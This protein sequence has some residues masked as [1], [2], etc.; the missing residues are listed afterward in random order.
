MLENGWTGREAC[1]LQSALRLSQQGFAARFGISMRTV[2]GW[3][4]YPG[5]RPRPETQKILDAAYADA[6][7]EE[8]ER[9]AAL[10][11][12]AAGGSEP[13]SAG[14]GPAPQGLHN[15]P[16]RGNVFV[17]RAGDL[18]WLETAIEQQPASVHGLGG[19]GKSTLALHFAHRC[20]EERRYN[21]VW[22][23]SAE[24]PVTVTTGLAE[25]A[26][27][28]NPGAGMAEKTSADAAAWAVGWLQAHDG[29]LLVYDDAS[30]RAVE[31]VL[32]TLS[33]GRHLITSRRATGWRRIARPLPLSLLPPSDAVDL[34]MQ[35]IVNPGDDSDR[36]VGYLPLALEQAAAYIEHT[37]IT[38]AGYLDRLRSYPARMLDAAGDPDDEDGRQRTIAR[39]F[40][41]SIRAIAGELPLAGEILAILA[42]L[43][44]DP[45]PRPVAYMLGPDPLTV[46]DALGKLHAYSMITLTPDT[47][48]I[49]RLVQAVARNPAEP[50]AAE[51]ARDRAVA[52]LLGILPPDPLFSPAG[53][54][55]WRELLPHVMALA[56]HV[57]P[58]QDTPGIAGILVAA[59][60]FAQADGHYE[61]A[62][63]FAERAAA[64]FA[65]LRGTDAPETLNA[66]SYLASAYRATGD[67]ATA[68]PLHES[69]LADAERVLGP[70]HP[71]T[72]VARANLAYLLAWQGEPARA[73]EMHAANAAAFERIHGPEHPHALNARANLAT[74]YRDAGDLAESIPLL[75]QSAADYA[76]VYGT[77]HP[78]TVTARS[79][80]A[81]AYQLAGDLDRAIPPLPA[82]P[83]RPRSALRPGPRLDANRP[84]ASQRSR[85]TGIRTRP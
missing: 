42:W 25:L 46:D 63:T 44:P 30:P 61:Q 78:E 28:L 51:K 76:R 27:R 4:E 15:L 70:D 73:A 8:R 47:I 62:V 84:A 55:Q 32:G 75:E 43:G 40:G 57:R 11:A 1:A 48:G 20:R 5:R 77:D 49:H 58:D 53:W 52:A 7:P 31:S 59:S 65:R 67:F 12:S 83:S 79:N 36:E 74:C 14:D 41:L 81:Y 80:L 66:R 23:L 56:G 29:W 2:A 3:A 45:I 71:D 21:P 64:A 34:L 17:D 72:L 68:A 26:A 16:A 38:P 33:V 6:T 82:S 24:S 37:Q 19:T 54:P 69:N 60:G 85:A 35:V 10:T 13:A 18:A 50:G 22:W 9:F 39:T